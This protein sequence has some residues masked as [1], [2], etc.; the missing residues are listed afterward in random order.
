[1][2]RW[3]RRNWFI[4]ILGSASL[5]GAC[6]RRAAPDPERRAEPSKAAPESTPEPE[7]AET[8]ACA[9]TLAALGAAP[10]LAGS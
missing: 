7:S 4:L 1:M 5:L 9:A 3:Q 6:G 2:S 8:R 10:E